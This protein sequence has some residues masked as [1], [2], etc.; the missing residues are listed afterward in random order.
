MDG[1][2]V[3]YENPLDMWM[4]IT[5]HRFVT[6]LVFVSKKALAQVSKEDKEIF[7]S[8]LKK[9]MV[10]ERKASA[11]AMRLAIEVLKNRG[12]HLNIWTPEQIAEGRKLFSSYSESLPPSV[13]AE[14]ALISSF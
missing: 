1:L 9:L 3:E 12:A 4:N 11:E 13:K 5:T 2:F 10:E 14:A 7:L 8:S 6:R